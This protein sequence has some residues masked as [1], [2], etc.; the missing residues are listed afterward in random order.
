M[1]CYRLL[2]AS[3]QPLDATGS[4]LFGGRFNSPGHPML[5]LAAS[6]AVAILEARVHNPKLG[7]AERMMHSIEVPDK[8]IAGLAD[9]KLKLPAGWNVVPASTVSQA[10][11]DEWSI[12]LRSLA[13]AVPS[14][15]GRGERS[16]ILVNPNHPDFH[17][18]RLT[19][20]ELFVFDSR[21]HQEE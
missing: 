6:E 9:L 18:I 13:L 4:I 10:F 7:G 20:S 5:Y 1:I 11:G 14:V 8:A 2:K 17:V 19:R 12:G 15:P 3:Y 21:L 16:N